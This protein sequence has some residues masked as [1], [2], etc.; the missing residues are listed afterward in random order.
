MMDNSLSRTQ[1]R[2]L[3]TKGVGVVVGSKV[4][5]IHPVG[6][7]NSPRATSHESTQVD[8]KSGTLKAKWHC[9]GFDPNTGLTHSQMS[10]KPNIVFC[11]PTL[12]IIIHHV[13]RRS[14]TIRERKKYPYQA[15]DHRILIKFCTQLHLSLDF[16]HTWYLH[17]FT[18][19]RSASL[20]KHRCY[21]YRSYQGHDFH[22]TYVRKIVVRARGYL[23]TRG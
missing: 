9:G 5:W 15:R 1:L 20:Y 18:Q 6:A 8:T 14:N 13:Y 22:M 12:T 23:T 10:T 7:I 17:L 4:G 3:E 21:M 19:L 2:Y 16:G 11:A